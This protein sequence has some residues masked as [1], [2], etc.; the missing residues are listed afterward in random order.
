[1]GAIGDPH[2]NF[3][4]IGRVMRDAPAV[5]FWMC[6]GDLGGDEGRYEQPAAPLY[7]IK[8]NNE[9][10]DFVAAQ[11]DSNEGNLHYIP[12]GVAVSASGVTIAGVG[13]T[14][15]PTWYETPAAQLPHPR[16]SKGAPRTPSAITRDKRRHFVEE[17]VRACGALKGVDLLLTHEAPKPFFVRFGGPSSG[18]RKGMDAGKEPINELLRT[19]RPR[20]H[21]FGHHHRYDDA[22]REGIRSVC[23]D[24]VS[25]SYLVIDPATMAIER[26]QS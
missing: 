3:E 22:I 17:E 9:D 18:R 21:L 23:L 8:G 5:A 19:M 16:F 6:V 7:W 11:G 24:P 14:F 13:G 15:A 2:G 12:N 25:I 1:L 20:L 4:A 10:F 26:V